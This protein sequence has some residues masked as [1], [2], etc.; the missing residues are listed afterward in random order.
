MKSL[1]Y[2]KIVVMLFL[3]VSAYN[4]PAM[5]DS[6]IYG[7]S[8]YGYNDLIEINLT[9][10]EAADVGDTTYQTQAIAWDPEFGVYYFE[11][12]T[13][14]EYDGTHFDYYDLSHNTDFNVKTYGEGEETFVKQLGFDPNGTLYGLDYQDSLST[15]N[16][17]TGEI[18][19]L[20]SVTGL[21]TG[22]HWG[23]TGDL[24]F[25]PD[26]T[27]YVAT[28]QSL[29]TLSQDD[30]GNIEATLLFENMI[31]EQNDPD[32]SLWTGLAYMDGLL[33]ASSAEMDDVDKLTNLKS[34]IYSIDPFSV[35][36]E[37]T[38]LLEAPHILND[39]SAGPSGSAVPIPGAVWLLG[40]GLVGLVL[41][42]KNL[43]NNSRA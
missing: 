4:G 9:Q 17:Y 33:Y 31:P 26:G 11:T 3:C 36:G 29:Y 42:R 18:I 35:G 2:N 40:S 37:V 8:A 23:R 19:E 39:L 24:A 12:Y 25:S 14:P 5:A 6:I 16:Q 34:V 41:A 43:K 30:K 15:I 32:L 27:L 22:G 13:L 10:G 38:W 7:A 20:G 1:L 28:Y 21:P